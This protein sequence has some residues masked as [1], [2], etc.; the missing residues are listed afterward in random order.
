[1]VEMSTS[2]LVT[3]VKLFGKVDKLRPGAMDK[4]A[5]YAKIDWQTLKPGIRAYMLRDS[6]SSIRIV[7]LYRFVVA[8][9][10][11]WRVYLRVF[12]DPG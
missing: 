8:I 9:A 4:R 12:S 2:H 5:G 1:M 11:W 7:N 3:E 6:A 10:K